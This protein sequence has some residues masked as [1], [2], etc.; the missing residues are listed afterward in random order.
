[1]SEFTFNEGGETFVI[2]GPSGLTFDQARTIF[3]QQFS[4]GSLTGFKVGDTLSAATQA[5]DGL[6]AASAQVSQGLASAS[7]LLPPGINASSITAALGTNGLSSLGQVGSAL[8]GTGA[9]AASLLTSGAGSFASGLSSNLTAGVAGLSSTLS[10]ATQALTGQAAQVGSLA[11]NAIK[12]LSGGIRGVPLN[13]IDT[14]NFTKQLPSLGA[15]GNLSQAD[16]TGTLAQASKMVGQSFDKISNSLGV[17]K[18]GFDAS[19]LEKAGMIKPGTAAA[20]LSGGEQ[21]IVN[22]LKSPTV[23]TG[24]DGVK[25]LEGLLKSN[26]LQDKIQQG[27][28]A[29]GLND[30][31]QLGVPVDNLKPEAL[32]GL[33]TNAAK[34]VPA[35]MDWL[36]NVPTPQIPTIPGGDVKSAFD[37][38]TTNGAFAVKFTN[39][40]VEPPLKQEEPVTPATDTVNTKTVDAAVTRVVG[41]E[42]VPDASG[43][44]TGGK[45]AA[46]VEFKKFVEN[47]TTGF[48]ELNQKINAINSKY[49][50]ITQEQWNVINNEAVVLRASVR[51][52][53]QD[54]NSAALKDVESIPAAN[55]TWGQRNALREYNTAL[56]D[57]GKMTALS[58][59]IRALIKD[60]ANKIYSSAIVRSTLT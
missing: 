60:L 32:S 44:T 47:T 3:T 34:S 57:F 6:A 46:I 45:Y 19:Q 48:Q 14:A 43:S 49:Q 22:T 35:T 31:K 4:T 28:M 53:L 41:N 17:G 21:D 52:R 2:K 55:Q 11:N 51:S 38:M 29:S 56:E 10:V 18:F 30:I 26:P 9:A 5:A 24:K 8:Q 13:G 40:K 27:L 25:S 23:W 59:E 42:K 39:D 16:V 58:D 7:K 12:T 1:M 15:I 54:L 37:K 20:F 33:L 50:A 36:K